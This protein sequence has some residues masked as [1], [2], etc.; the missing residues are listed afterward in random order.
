MNED[1]KFITN[2][3]LLLMLQIFVTFL[4]IYSVRNYF[5]N[6]NIEKYWFLYFILSLVIIVALGFVKRSRFSLSILFCILL[7]LMLYASL[8]NVSYEQIKGSFIGAVLVFVFFTIVAV[9]LS[10]NNID[11]SGWGIYLL[12]ALIGL[13]VFGI[14]NLFI[15]SRQ[16]YNIYIAIGLILFSIFVVYD[17]NR[18]LLKQNRDIIDASISFYLDFINI[19][20][21]MNNN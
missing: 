18:L 14:I 17:T 2:V 8:K 19:F 7:G 5:P 10:K 6:S 9:Y 3:Y 15:R 11:M 4:T 20:S 13:I 1:S 21:L 12:G 16:L